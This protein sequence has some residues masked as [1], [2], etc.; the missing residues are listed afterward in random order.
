MASYINILPTRTVNCLLTKQKFYWQ[1][2]CMGEDVCVLRW[3]WQWGKGRRWQRELLMD[4]HFLFGHPEVFQ[5][6]PIC[7]VYLMLSPTLDSTVNL[8]A[9]RQIVE[10]IKG[11][12]RVL[13]F[14]SSHNLTFIYVL[15][16]FAIIAV[17]IYGLQY[18]LRFRQ[19]QS[20]NFHFRH[21]CSMKA[22][23]QLCRETHL[24]K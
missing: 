20:L 10:K 24:I 3:V 21:L 15:R 9:S 7:S 19:R 8:S 12:G 4:I 22:L 16:F 13:L 17:N 5:H 11:V 18:R 1:Q 6:K 2:P 14:S 23:K